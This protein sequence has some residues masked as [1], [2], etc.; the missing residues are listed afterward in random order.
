M[1]RHMAGY[2]NE[3]SIIGIGSMTVQAILYLWW[4]CTT[5]L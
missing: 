4:G 5:E 1:L 3:E 2:N